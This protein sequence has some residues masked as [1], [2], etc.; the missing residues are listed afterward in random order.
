MGGEGIRGVA[1][2]NGRE[3]RRGLVCAWNLRVVGTSRLVRWIISQSIARRPPCPGV[4][5]C[6]GDLARS[7]LMPAKCFQKASENQGPQV[8][9]MDNASCRF[10]RTIYVW[11]TEHSW[12]TKTFQHGLCPA[13]RF[14]VEER[15][16]RGEGRPGGMG[17]QEGRSGSPSM[18]VGR[19]FVFVRGNRKATRSLDYV[20]VPRGRVVTVEYDTRQLVHLVYQCDDMCD[21]IMCDE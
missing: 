17:G 1:V 8:E 21:S 18:N 4:S 20:L 2:G 19:A 13:S 11:L 12:P 9:L 14:R 3:S 7:P 15:R 10:R 16:K 6:G 5:Q